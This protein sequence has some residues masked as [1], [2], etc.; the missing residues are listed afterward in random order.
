MQNKPAPTWDVSSTKTCKYWDKLPVNWFAGFLSTVR[1]NYRQD[2]LNESCLD[3]A[4]ILYIDLQTPFLL[5]NHNVYFMYFTP[6]NPL[7][8]L[9]FFK[10][11][12]P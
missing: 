10:L 9:F 2:A 5:I 3:F 7:C 6:Q 4:M 12:L 11:T 8:P 1:D